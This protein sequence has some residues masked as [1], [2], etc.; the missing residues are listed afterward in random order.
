LSFLKAVEYILGIGFFGFMYWLLDGIRTEIMPISER[1]NVY[2]LA[3]YIWVASLIIYLIFGGI[4]V[5]RS[6]VEQQYS[7]R[8]N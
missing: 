4:W 3:D 2:S 6:Y 1:G 5:V 8:R 7:L